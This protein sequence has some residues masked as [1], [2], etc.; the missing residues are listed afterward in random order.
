M[1]T[2]V[3]PVFDSGIG[4]HPG[5]VLEHVVRPVLKLLDLPSPE[6]AERL[7]MGTAAQES[8][9]RYLEQLG[10]GPALGLW[11]MEPATFRDLWERFGPNPLRPVETQRKLAQ[12]LNSLRAPLLVLPT[13]QL[14]W[15]LQLACAMCRVHYYA[16]PFSL[17]QTVGEVD[18]SALAL[19]WK[20]HYNT[21]QGKG[22]PSEFVENY[23]KFVAPLYE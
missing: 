8:R 21:V 2:T 1:T 19:I 5:H 7:V 15:N 18:T 6:V 22:K 9:F 4:L 12:K 23:K 14:A 11:Q 17:P 3:V 13:D 20:T 10:G 16:R